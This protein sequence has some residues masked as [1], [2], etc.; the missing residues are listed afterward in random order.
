[1]YI[2]IGLRSARVVCV[3]VCLWGS[4]ASAEPRG[5]PVVFPRTMDAKLVCRIGP[6]PLM[7]GQTCT[8]SETLQ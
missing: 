8:I 5:L 3:L 4:A 2:T 6:S 7:Q 1:M